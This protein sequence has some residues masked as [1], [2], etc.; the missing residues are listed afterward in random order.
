MP[1]AQ[2]DAFAPA[3]RDTIVVALAGAWTLLLWVSRVR[4]ITDA[5]LAEWS[6]L[7][8]IGISIAFGA[9]LAVIAVMWRDGR[10]NRW[11]GPAMIGFALW[12]VV[13]WGTSLMSVLAGDEDT[14][15][16]VVHSLLAIASLTLGTLVGGVGRREILFY[17]SATSTHAAPSTTAK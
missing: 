16:K 4:L 17:P 5:E 13:A 12:M 10:R 15:F 7:A 6:N 14:A 2:S 8:R 11:A 1:N 9:A 3:R